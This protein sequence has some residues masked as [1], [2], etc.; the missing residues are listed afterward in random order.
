MADNAGFFSNLT[1]LDFLKAGAGYLGQ[2]EQTKVE[3][4]KAQTAAAEAAQRAK[5]EAA[6]IAAQRSQNA[7]AVAQQVFNNQQMWMLARWLTLAGSTALVGA[8]V[9]KIVKGK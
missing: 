5:I 8:I 4:V 9:L 1:A 2:K 7:Q 6:N 3:K